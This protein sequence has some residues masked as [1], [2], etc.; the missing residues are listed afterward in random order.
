MS[1]IP[2]VSWT[3]SGGDGAWA[4]G[5]QACAA[6]GPTWKFS[7]PRNGYENLRAVEELVIAGA[8]KAW[9]NFASN[10]NDRWFIGTPSR[11]DDFTVSPSPH[12]TLIQSERGDDHRARRRRS[13][14]CARTVE[15]VAFS[16]DPTMRPGR[17]RKP[18]IDTVR[19]S[20][21]GK[22]NGQPGYRYEVFAVD[23]GE[24]G[25]HPESVRITV[26]NPAGQI[27]AHV[28]GEIGGGNV[29]SKR[30]GH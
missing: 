22:W 26:R 12:Y 6:F 27:V 25:R 16:D 18:Q 30:I 7:P 15:F 29:Q 10:G 20:G 11:I 14:C 19:F 8:G 23:H 21:V 5:H 4:A 2:T 1:D 13:R 3:L 28:D 24:A 17:A 9:I